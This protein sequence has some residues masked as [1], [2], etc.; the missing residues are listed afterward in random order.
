MDGCLSEWIWWVS[1]WKEGRQAKTLASSCGAQ[2]F[3]AELAM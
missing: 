1:K 3:E 2:T